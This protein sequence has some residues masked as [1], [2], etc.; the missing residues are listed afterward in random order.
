MTRDVPLLL[1][2]TNIPTPEVTDF[3]TFAAGAV[4]VVQVTPS[5]EAIARA[6]PAVDTPTKKP[7]P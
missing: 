2:A 3:Q 5:A 1:T 7:L 4:L 6:E